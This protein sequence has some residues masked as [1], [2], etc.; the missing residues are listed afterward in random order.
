MILRQFLH[1]DPVGI[2]YLFSCGGQ[3]AGAV[4]HPAGDIDGSCAKPMTSN[5]KG[6]PYE[7]SQDAYRRVE[8][9]ADHLA[10]LELGTNSNRAQQIRL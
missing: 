4:V 5:R 3:A 10:R 9:S 7:R 1:E 8:R 6:R 2:S